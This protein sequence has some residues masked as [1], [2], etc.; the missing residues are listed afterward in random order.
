MPLNQRFATLG[1]LLRSSPRF[2]LHGD[3]LFLASGVRNDRPAVGKVSSRGPLVSTT[4]NDL[5]NLRSTDSALIAGKP[6]YPVFLLAQTA[7]KCIG[8]PPTGRFDSCY[9]NYLLHPT[10]YS[11]AEAKD[12]MGETLPFEAVLVEAAPYLARLRI[13][14]KSTW[15]HAATNLTQVGLAL[16]VG[17]STMVLALFALHE[18]S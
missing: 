9:V 6:A 18:G 17:V 12:T 4:G 3:C 1:R 11:A 5:P 13:A 15:E 8:G 14:L 10:H 16:V 7:Y 2:Q